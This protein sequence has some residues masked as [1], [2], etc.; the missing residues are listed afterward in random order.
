MKHYLFIFP[1]S[2][3]ENILK[4]Q[5]FPVISYLNQGNNRCSIYFE[6]PIEMKQYEHVQYDVVNQTDLK[7]VMR[8]ADY[9]YIRNIFTFIKYF[10]SKFRKR[11]SFKL[12]YDFRGFTAFESF[13]VQKNPIK[14]IVALF[15][16]FL[17]YRLSDEILTVSEG[18][19]SKLAKLYGKRD[20]QVLPCCTSRI[21]KKESI[22]D[23]NK[24]VKF[25][26][27]GGLDKWQ[28]IDQILILYSEL[29]K[30]FKN[31]SL[32]IYTRSTEKAKTILAEHNLTDVTVDSLPHEKLMKKLENYN[33]AFL[34][35]DDI[36]V[37]NVASPIKFAEYISAGLI[38]ILSPGIGDYSSLVRE[39]KIGLITDKTFHVD[40]KNL[41]EII[42]DKS[43]FD[44]IFQI[45][46]TYQWENRLPQISVYN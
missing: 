14:F 9:L 7:E 19:K 20:V 30:L 22:L 25:V 3:N 1:K 5:L 8:K 34:L 16:E 39:E 42:E 28:K 29:S 17:A 13:Y 26:Y 27:C 37:N 4:S 44:R 23:I 40:E 10:S 2:L 6:K 41:G 15:F 36:T 21:I 11:N 32:P 45:A 12:I 35:R 24:E 33:F 38:P 43:I 46:Q 31:P 18:F